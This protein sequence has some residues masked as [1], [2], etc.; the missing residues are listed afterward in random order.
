MKRLVLLVALLVGVL[1]A[2]VSVRLQNGSTVLRDNVSGRLVLKCDGTS[3]TCTFANNNQFTLGIGTGT[4]ADPGG[5]GLV[6]RTA[7]G[8]TTARS[9]AISAPITVSNADGTAGNPTLGCTDA[10]ATVGGCLTSSTQ[11]LSGAKTLSTTTLLGLTSN[12]G[13]VAIAALATPTIT[14]VTPQTAGGGKT[15]TYKVVCTVSDATHTAASAAST[16]ADA[17]ADLTAANHGNMLVFPACPAGSTGNLVVYRTA[18]NGTTPAGGAATGLIATLAATAT[19]YTDAGANG[20]GA[21]PPSANNTGSVITTITGK[22]TNFGLETKESSSGAFIGFIPDASSAAFN[23]L[24][25]DTD[26]VL[27]FSNNNG[28]SNGG[29]LAIV[30]WAV[31]GQGIRIDG[32]TGRVTVGAL[33]TATNCADSAGAAACGSAAAGA[34]VID[35]GSTSTVVSTTAVTANS[36]IFLQEDSSLGTR[37]GITCNTQSVLVLGSPVVTARTAA[38]SFTATIVVAPTTNPMCVNYFIVN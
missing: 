3:L 34:F 35:A 30:P 15:A 10:S 6:V 28:G 26:N 22:S 17:A 19:G 5:N 29:G 12:T 36:Q 24:V 1:H 13:N 2:Q 14:S 8:V 27:V 25:A 4:L 18:F 38:T 31:S 7:A 33:G 9:I 23:T 11:T 20:D 32:V 21:T 37:L 16:T